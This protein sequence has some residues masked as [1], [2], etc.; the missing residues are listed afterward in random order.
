MDIVNSEN[1][2]ISIK[3]STIK[4]SYHSFNRDYWL[5]A[6]F[7]PCKTKR[8]YITNIDYS[9]KENCIEVVKVYHSRWR[10]EEY[11]RFIKQEYSFEKFK[12][13]S[14]KAINNLCVILMIVTT[15]IAEI[16][17]NKSIAYYHCL[18][19]YKSFEDKEVCGTRK[20]KE[21]GLMLY[22]IKRGMSKI[23][24]HTAKLPEVPGKNR[25]IKYKQ[26][27]LF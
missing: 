1:E 4:V 26:L 12:V 11:F 3:L 2:K 10:I 25:E 14:L 19:A 6:E 23:L 20:Y 15:Y 21:S 8:I 22:R 27:K 17:V 16:I 5:V 9:N 13:K 7:L 24:T 18:E